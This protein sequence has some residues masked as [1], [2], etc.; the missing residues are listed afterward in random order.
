MTTGGRARPLVLADRIELWDAALAATAACMRA[1]GLHEVRTPPVVDEVALEPWIEPV[2]VGAR[3]VQTSP[4][5]AMKRLLAHGAGDMFQL[6]A[7]ARAGERGRWHAE[8]FTL[9]E[10]YRRGDAQLQVRGDV[11][12]V[13]AALFDALAPWQ[14]AATRGPRRWSSV[15]WL[16]AFADATGVALRGDEDGDELVARVHDCWPTP[17]L[18]V[19]DP[20]ARTLEAWT[21]CFTG[22]CDAHLD[23]WLRARADEGVAVHLVEFPRALAA[24]SETTRDAHGRAVAARFE[25]HVGGRELANGYGELRDAV[26]QRRRFAAVAALRA[27]YGLPALPLPSAFLDTL[28]H[29]GLPRCAGAALGLERIIAI[30]IG[31]DGIEAH[32]LSP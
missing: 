16:D 28:A 2:A 19:V 6:A 30:A 25:S 24:L 10:W 18:R 23:G 17:A 3:F 22:F 20:D 32:A 5:L 12:A 1:R 15:A 31:A 14:R 13:V 21:S 7:V 4:E 8:Q 26:E 9:L 29:P 27:A 11:E